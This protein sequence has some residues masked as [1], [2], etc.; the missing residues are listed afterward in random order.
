MGGPCSGVWLPALLLFFFHGLLAWAAEV[1]DYYKLLGITEYADAD[2]IKKAYRQSSLKYHPDKFQG[3]PAEAQAKMVQINDAFKCL[4]NPKTRRM[5]EYYPSD[6]ESMA[7]YEEQLKKEQRRQVEEPDTDHRLE[8][9]QP[10]RRGFTEA[11]CRVQASRQD[12]REEP[13]S[14]GSSREL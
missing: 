6:Y 5:Y 1:V 14:A 4:K 11:C 8:S 3:D 2:E 12:G 9:L 7:E 13:R 10:T